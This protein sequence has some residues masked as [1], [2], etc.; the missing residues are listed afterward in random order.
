MS[1]GHRALAAEEKAW[2]RPKE[3]GEVSDP[4]WQP[5][6]R[7]GVPAEVAGQQARGAEA[8]FGVGTAAFASP[9]TGWVYVGDGE[10][11]QCRV[12]FTDDAGATWSPQLAWRGLFYGRLA[13]FGEREAGFGLSVSR[14][15]DING[16]RPDPHPADDPFIGTDA[17]LAGTQNAGVT[18]TLAPIPDRRASGLYFLTPRRIWLTLYLSEVVP[19]EGGG[20]VVGDGGARTWVLREGGVRTDLMRTP[21]GGVTWQRLRRMDGVGVMSVCFQSEAEGLMVATGE[22]N[23]MDLLYRTVDGGVSLERVPLAPP[24]GLSAS[25]D[26]LLVPVAGLGGGVLLVLSARSRS[27]SERRPRWEGSYVY[28][29]D[30]QGGWAGP[31]PLPLPSARL[32][33]PHMAAPGPDG[34]VWAAADRDLLVADD[35]AGPW[36]HQTVPLPAGQVITGLNPVG[37]GVLWLTTRRFP[38]IEAVYGGQLYRSADDGANWTRVLVDST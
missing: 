19:V 33:P 14:G 11:A 20:H 25:A 30:G 3:A 34:R 21:D 18:W 13:V 23:R 26:T 37:D 29:A 9:T 12:L 28:A 35:P 1:Q 10:S 4:G 31:F 6:P 5:F 8:G 24:R 38:G 7:T 16:Y 22:R 15:D 2:E 32:S 27:D 36:R 17:F